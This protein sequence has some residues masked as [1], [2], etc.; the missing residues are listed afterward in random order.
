MTVEETLSRNKISQLGYPF[1]GEGEYIPLTKVFWVTKMRPIKL[2]YSWEKIYFWSGSPH[3]DCSIKPCLARFY[4]CSKDNRNTCHAFFGTVSPCSFFQH[5][6]TSVAKYKN[7][8]TS[9]SDLQFL[10]LYSVLIMSGT[11]MQNTDKKL[12]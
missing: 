1:I 8:L 4:Y 3:V 5:C 12:Q 2:T 10:L 7:C 11:R 9:F 6:L